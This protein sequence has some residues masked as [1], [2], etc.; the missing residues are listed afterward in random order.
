MTLKLPMPA[1]GNPHTG[2]VQFGD[3]LPGI[4][5]TAEDAFALRLALANFGSQTDS[6]NPDVA[7]RQRFAK[8]LGETEFGTAAHLKKQIGGAPK[9]LATAA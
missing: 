7:I 3:E 4:Y 2:L 1:T 6:A 9:P 8:L 5:I